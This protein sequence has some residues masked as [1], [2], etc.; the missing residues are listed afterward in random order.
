MNGFLLTGTSA[1]ISPIAV[2]LFLVVV[3]GGSMALTQ[4]GARGGAK[5]IR[6]RYAGRIRDEGKFIGPFIYLLTDQE[7]VIQK[8]G[9]I[10]AVYPYEEIKYAVMWWDMTTRSYAVSLFGDNKKKPIPPTE[11][12]GGT[13]VAQK[14][15]AK[16]MNLMKKDEAKLFL[17]KL[18]NQASHIEIDGVNV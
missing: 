12:I 13:A 16:G 5:K 11:L 2:I 10:F 7:L 18:K 9:A 1:D 17:E 4:S 15:A 3:I 8:T 14:L 6:E